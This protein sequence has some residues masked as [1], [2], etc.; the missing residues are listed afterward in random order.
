MNAE[1]IAGAAR[2]AAIKKLTAGVNARIA[3][4]KAQAKVQRK[5]ET[6]LNLIDAR[7]EWDSC[8]S[9]PNCVNPGPR[10]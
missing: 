10:P 7:S 9:N 5:L 4:L 3:E 8:A 2:L 6:D 1:R